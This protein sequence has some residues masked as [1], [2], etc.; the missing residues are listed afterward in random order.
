M[1][2]VILMRAW[3]AEKDEKIAARTWFKTI[4]QRTQIEKGDL[5]IPRYSALPFFNELVNDVQYLGGKVIND[6]RQHRFIADL[7]NWYAVLSDLTPKTWFRLEDI[8]VEENG[9]FVLKGETN[10]KKHQWTTQ[11]YAP[12][13][14]EAFRVYWEL[15]N[16][17]LIADQNVYIRKFVKLK[18]FLDGV[19]G[20]PVTNEWRTFVLYGEVLA[21]GYYWSNYWDDLEEKPQMDEGAKTLLQTVISRVGCDSNFYVIDIGQLEDG[22]WVV[23]ELN[24]GMMSGL[25]MID[26]DELYKKMGQVLRRNEN[27]NNI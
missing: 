17:G 16:D 15:S 21:S 18:K 24:D 20:M 9:P 6:V 5:V 1:N 2:P 10:S 12:N 3:L 22:S 14:K 4:I 26:P 27:H 19:N 7:E 23:I 11:M 8:P 25:S 13:R